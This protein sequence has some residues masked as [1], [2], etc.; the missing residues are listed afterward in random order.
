MHD[1]DYQF[2]QYRRDPCCC[3]KHHAQIVIHQ[4]TVLVG[5]SPPDFGI[6]ATKRDIWKVTMNS[7]W[8][9]YQ[10]CDGIRP[11]QMGRT[12]R[13]DHKLLQCL[14]KED[15]RRGAMN[16]SSASLPS[17]LPLLHLSPSGS[18]LRAKNLRR[19]PHSM[20]DDDDDMAGWLVGCWVYVY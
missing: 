20:A 10:F 5:A 16:H 14:I 15:T 17:L 9:I 8:L 4:L 6:L 2:W 7:F 19:P 12:H 13:T 3:L 1:G 11:Y 18:S